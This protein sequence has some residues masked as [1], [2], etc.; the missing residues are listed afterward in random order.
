MHANISHARGVTPVHEMEAK[1]LARLLQST[2]ARDDEVHLVIYL[3][4][5]KAKK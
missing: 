2:A 5:Q 4:F 3:C 1:K